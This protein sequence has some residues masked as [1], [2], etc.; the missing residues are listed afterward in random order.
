MTA[1][2]FEC[3]F[4]TQ[5]DKGLLFVSTQSF[6]F[7]SIAAPE[8]GLVVVHWR[9]VASVA[10]SSV[11]CVTLSLVDTQSLRI[12]WAPPN[13]AAASTPT[14]LVSYLVHVCAPARLDSLRGA[15]DSA[16]PSRARSEKALDAALTY[17]YQAEATAQDT[18]AMLDRQSESLHQS[19]RMAE[20][21]VAQSKLGARIIS[22]IASIPSM[23][24]Q[25][26]WGSSAS[27]SPSSETVIRQPNHTATFNPDDYDDVRSII[28]GSKNKDS[29]TAHRIL[30]NWN[31]KGC[32][33]ATR[34][35]AL[36]MRTTTV[37]S[38]LGELVPVFVW[39]EKGEIFSENVLSSRREGVTAATR[40]WVN[41]AAT[42]WK[43]ESVPWSVGCLRTDPVRK[44]VFG[45]LICADWRRLCAPERVDVIDASWIWWDKARVETQLRCVQPTG[46]GGA[47]PLST[48][49]AL[50]DVR[51]DGLSRAVGRLRAHSVAMH[52]TLQDQNDSLQRLIETAD[53]ANS[54]LRANNAQVRDLLNG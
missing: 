29:S 41:A 31:A 20:N 26:L 17:A 51:V 24:W 48:T 49:T 52:D 30:V 8:R 33:D 16:Q 15:S 22:S 4:G 46:G 1:A 45:P 40:V 42:H 44:W 38:R 43:A 13:N 36:M 9:D 5:Q 7:E 53:S 39:M 28:S 23:L 34:I 10:A 21:T 32:K 18:A 25:S 35:P 54:K 12:G 3:Y 37:W 14:V 2:A 47:C 50:R 27:V 6:C 19:A 11:S